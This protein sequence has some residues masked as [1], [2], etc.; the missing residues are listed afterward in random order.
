MQRGQAEQGFDFRCLE[1]QRVAVAVET[2]QRL[3][4]ELELVIVA[5]QALGRLLELGLP[6]SRELAADTRR[7]TAKRATE[8]GSVRPGGT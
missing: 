1:E 4:E 5:R 6:G 3:A 7:A 8:R 2:L